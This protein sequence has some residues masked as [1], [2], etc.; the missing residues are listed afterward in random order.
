MKT[1]LPEEHMEQ[2]KPIEG[3]NEKIEVSNYGRVRSLLRGYPKILRTQPDKKGYLRVRTS[4]A[5]QKKSYKIHRE[6]AKAFLPNPNNLPQVNH[7]DGKKNNNTVS[8]LEWVTNAENAR[9]AIQSGL[10]DRVIEGALKE[11]ERRKKPITGYRQNDT[12]TET[13][14]FA[15]ISDAERYFDSRHICDVLKGKRKHVKGWGFRYEEVITV[16]NI[17]HYAAE[18]QAKAISASQN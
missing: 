10:W 7:K 8:N 4:I 15:C 2:W 5:G 17:D 11:N 6:V 3:T 18:R 1:F 13:I 14:S 12:K 9:H 16:E